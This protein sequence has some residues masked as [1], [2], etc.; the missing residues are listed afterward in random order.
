M[1]SGLWR[2]QEC[3][4]KKK[5]KDHNLNNKERGIIIFGATCRLDLIHVP[6]KLHEYIPDDFLVMEC[7]EIVKERTDDQHRA[8]IHPFFFISTRAYNKY[9]MAHADSYDIGQPV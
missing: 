8:I 9:L 7:T 1:V 6:T 5:T 2:V 4:D 3:N